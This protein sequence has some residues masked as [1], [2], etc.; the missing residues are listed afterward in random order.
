MDRSEPAL[1]PEWLKSRNGVVANNGTLNHQ[2]STSSLSVEHHIGIFSRNRSC[3]VH[4]E[5]NLSSS[6]RRCSSS[7][8][9]RT[10]DKDRAGKSRTYSSFGRS[11]REREL[12]KDFNFRDRGDRSVLVDNGFHDNL[13]TFLTSSS[14]RDTLRHSH[15]VVPGK[16]IGTL[17]R[18]LGLN[19]SNGIR[20]RTKSASFEK[21][22]PSLGAEEK[23]GHPDASRVSSPGISL[24]IQTTPLGTATIPGIDTWNSALV[25]PVKAAENGLGLSSKQQTAATPVTV[26][27]MAETVA[28]APSRFR[29]APQ[30]S[31][32]TQRIEELTLRQCKQLIP[33]TPSMPKA[34]A[35]NSM[36]KLKNKGARGGDSSNVS[37]IGQQLSSQPGSLAPRAQVRSD[38]TKTSVLGGFQVL[39]REKSGTFPATKDGPSVS[40]VVSPVGLAPSASILSLK[41]PSNQKLKGE[42]KDVTLSSTHSPF[43]EKRSHSQSKERH[44]FFKYIRDKTSKGAIPEQDCITS[45][46]SLDDSGEHSPLNHE[47]V[48]ILSDSG[49]NCSENGHYVTKTADACGESKRLPTEIEETDPCS[50]PVDP[51]EKALLRL[52]GWDENEKVDALTKEEI[53]AF[54]MKYKELEQS[55]KLS[56]QKIRPLK[57]VLAEISAGNITV[58][59]N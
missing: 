6:L 39:N 35:S 54:Y 43:G 27:N 15:P 14:E 9:A 57:E 32:Q 50:E 44:E 58:S 16:T 46:S 10:H 38:S 18:G 49:L 47:K 53:D 29:S 22:F 7:N 28:Q 48:D 24:P 31:T 26:L 41:S 21:D 8:G 51:E 3:L 20:G 1:K 56:Q 2:T 33:V 37:K 13:E 40:N 25:I 19:S 11:N 23:N 36:E 45:S 52:L 5:R 34:S 59:M 4:H 42:N 30:L 55:S 12:D 17:T